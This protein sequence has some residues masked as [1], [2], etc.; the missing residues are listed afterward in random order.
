MATITV[1]E[2]GAVGFSLKNKGIDLDILFNDYFD[3]DV[4]RGLADGKQT[5]L[6][7]SDSHGYVSLVSDGSTVTFSVSKNSDLGDG[8]ISIEVPF[9]SCADVFATCLSLRVWEP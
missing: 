8:N 3:E 5:D 6:T 7:V 4:W 2:Y 9:C 1:A